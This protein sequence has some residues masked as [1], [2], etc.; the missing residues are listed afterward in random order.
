MRIIL[1][2]SGVRAAIVDTA[3]GSVGDSTAAN[4]NATA[5]GIPGMSQWMKMPMPSTVK[6]TRPRAR[7]STAGAS[8]RSASLGM[9][10]PSRNS[11]GGRNSRKK[12]SGSSTTEIRPD[13]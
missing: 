1:S 2:G 13:W 5:I 9:R 8:R 3:T 10:H 7:L 6:T 11:S 4:A 12:T